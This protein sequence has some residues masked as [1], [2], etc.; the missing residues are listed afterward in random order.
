MAN[1]T[2]TVNINPGE[3]KV[4]SI[5]ATPSESL[6][7]I[8]NSITGLNTPLNGINDKLNNLGS[9]IGDALTEPLE[10]IGSSIANGLT[11]PLGEIKDSVTELT[12]PLGEIKDSVTELIGSL[13]EINES[14]SNGFEELNNT[15][16]DKLDEIYKT[17][18]R[19]ANLM[20]LYPEH[21]MRDTAI[22]LYSN[23]NFNIGKSAS[24]LADAAIERAK[25][26]TTKLFTDQPFKPME[27]ED[28]D[29]L[30]N[31]KE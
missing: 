21:V 6:T 9:S 3:S 28:N 16:N 11:G 17:L 12:G 23:S 10:N 4:V 22:K 26:F 15:A 25:L 2:Q 27:D 1:Q 13:G 30:K 8:K 19:I 14:V 7:E 20:E 31:R 18:K 5:T 29:R 24:E